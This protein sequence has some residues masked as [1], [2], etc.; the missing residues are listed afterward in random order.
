MWALA[1][2]DIRYFNA[3][4]QDAFVK[5][6]VV[7]FVRVAEFPFPH[8]HWGYVRQGGK[9]RLVPRLRHLQNQMG[10]L[11]RLGGH[12]VQ[13]DRQIDVAF[14]FEITPSIASKQDD[15]GNFRQ[16]FRGHPVQKVTDS[17]ERPWINCLLVH[18]PF[19]CLCR[20]VVA[21]RGGN[22]AWGGFGVFSALHAPD[23]SM[24]GKPY[25]PHCTP[26]PI[27]LFAASHPHA[28]PIQIAGA[29]RFIYAVRSHHVVN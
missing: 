16:P 15:P 12:A 23:Y 14:L 2:A 19:E 29:A 9:Q 3:F 18:R 26:S 10:S 24:L 17:S 13:G 8:N 11:P 25:R 27:A 1:S 20:H 6:R 22:P 21:L 28:V 7:C 4:V 5:L